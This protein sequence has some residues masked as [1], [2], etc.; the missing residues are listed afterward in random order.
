MTENLTIG[1]NI[2]RPI[3]GPCGQVTATYRWTINTGLN[4]YRPIFGPC[5]QV[6][7]NYRWTINTGLNVYVFQGLEINQTTTSPAHLKVWLNEEN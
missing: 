7:A 3:F 5:G 2:Y 1:L 4:I 6:T